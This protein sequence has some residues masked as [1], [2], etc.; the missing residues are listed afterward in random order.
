MKRPNA[1][2]DRNV[3]FSWLFRKPNLQSPK[4]S[5]RTEY[6]D[7]YTD[8][9]S[10]L[11]LGQS[12]SPLVLLTTLTDV[13]SGNLAFE[14]SSCIVG[15]LK[16]LYD[17]GADQSVAYAEDTAGDITATPKSV[18]PPAQPIIRDADALRAA[19]AA[20][21]ESMRARM[22]QMSRTTTSS[23]KPPSQGKRHT[24][25]KAPPS[26]PHGS[27]PSSKPS[28]RNVS[29]SRRQ[30]DHARAVFYDDN[31]INFAGNIMHGNVPA[32]R[33]VHCKTPLTTKQLHEALSQ[34]RKAEALEEK[35]SPKLFFFF[36]F[37]GCVSLQLGLDQNLVHGV[38]S[39]DPVLAT[40]FGDNER[41][42]ALRTLLGTLL[43]AGRC[44]IIT[45]NM[46]HAA[47]AHLLNLLLARGDG[48]PPKV[49]FAVG[50]S[51]RYTPSGTKIR[52]I[53]NILDARGCRLVSTS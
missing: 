43:E 30:Y 19:N 1:V 49:L 11:S 47:I 36:D 45:A 21:R 10:A 48:E 25:G 16:I 31:M 51:V 42:S 2:F 53:A 29:S 5:K 44:Y 18:P 6:M 23:F 15:D 37:D 52:A 33:T 3:T 41:Q 35:D 32:I 8:S 22:A 20:A 9:L 26:T 39:V 27:T 17:M 12:L 4:L 40:L 24:T 34:W 46:G 7:M 28:A 38:V 14:S 50:K 13:A